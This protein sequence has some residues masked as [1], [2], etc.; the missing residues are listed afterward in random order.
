MALLARSDVQVSIP[1]DDALGRRIA[2]ALREGNFVLLT[3]DGKPLAEVRPVRPL[4]GTVR[5]DSDDDLMS[6]EWREE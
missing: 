3:S 2:E 1:A 6:S 5:Y 4:L